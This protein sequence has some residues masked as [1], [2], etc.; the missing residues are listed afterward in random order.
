MFIPLKYNIRNLA[1][2][3]TA[4]L[5][6]AFGIAV[7]VAVFVSVMA[8]VEGMDDTFVTTGDARNI[9]ALRRGALSE[10]GSIIDIGAP[11]IVRNF[12]GIDAI[13][14]ER[15][16]YVNTPRLAGNGSSNVVIRGLGDTGRALRPQVH[17]LRG[18]WY[19][20]GAR[21]L[22]VSRSIASRF[23]DTDLGDELKTG[24]ARWKVVGIFDAG[25]TAYSSEMWTD[26]DGPA[27]A[28]QRRAWSDI[29]VRATN[30]AAIAPL[31]QMLDAESRIDV[32][33]RTEV[34]YFAEQTKASSPVRVLGNVVAI[35]MAV[36]SAF[37]AMNTMYAAVGSR[38]REI[39]VLR[40]LGFSG[41]A[42]ALSFLSEAVLLSIV[43]GVIGGLAA[44]P[45]NGIATGT[46]NWFTFAE[47]NFAF[48]I[49]ASLLGR[50]ILFAILMGAVG[51][52]LPALRASRLSAASAMRAL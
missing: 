35:I 7:S 3:R 38:T 41:R 49:T 18:R 44:L 25:N 37:A 42:V 17:L 47:M 1:V 11:L 12:P 26:P 30:K 16:V 31:L 39:A 20:P 36:G 15:L 8:L 34:E 48:A 2:R 27:A 10:T 21:E 40:A 29:V 50:G 4:T 24:S 32:D 52:V 46:T 9:I 14:A 19:R 23:R 22:T 13:S 5:L 45:L 33:A 43:G 51:G 28:F 6:T